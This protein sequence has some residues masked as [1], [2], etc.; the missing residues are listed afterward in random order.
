MEVR[1]YHL[2]AGYHANHVL[3]NKQHQ[4]QLESMY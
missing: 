4:L 1:P 3:D 2:D